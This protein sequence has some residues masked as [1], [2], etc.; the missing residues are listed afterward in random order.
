MPKHALLGAT[1]ATGS[2]I[3]QA[4]LR[5]PPSDMKLSIFVRSKCKLLS[6]FQDL[7]TNPPFPVT[8][9]EA[10]V[11]LVPAM[12]QCIRNADVIHMCVATNVPASSNRVAQDTAETLVAA[13]RELREELASI[14]VAPTMLI[15]RSGSVNDD[16]NKAVPAPVHTFL[17]YALHYVYHDLDLACQYYKL[18]ADAG[19]KRLLNYIYVDPPSIH[20]SGPKPTGYEFI[21]DVAAKPPSQSISYADLGA[22]FVEIADRQEAFRGQALIV[23]A[24]GKVEEHWLPLVGNMLM[25]LKSRIIG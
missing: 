8:I 13:L 18:V 25:G 14:Y 10:P 20:D 12:K 6:S 24:T 7:D 4:V 5:Y 11:F 19:D 16:Y 17:M 3:L 15:L 9:T 21:S 23:S 1:G 2:A 22:A